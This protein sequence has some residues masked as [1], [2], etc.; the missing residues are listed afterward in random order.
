MVRDAE[1]RTQGCEATYFP[2]GTP[3][4]GLLAPATCQAMSWTMGTQSSHSWVSTA[5]VRGRMMTDVEEK[6]NIWG[7]HDRGQT[8]F[9]KGFRI[10]PKD[11]MS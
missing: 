8:S 7:A 9:G 4:E 10:N 6:C 5:G 11:S 3:A 2:A 1:A